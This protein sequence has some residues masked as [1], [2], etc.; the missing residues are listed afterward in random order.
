MISMTDILGFDFRPE[1]YYT[2]DH[3]WAKLEADGTVKVGFDDVIAK[4][5]HEIFYLKLNSKGSIAKQKQKL[6]VLESRK[7]TGPIPSPISGEILAVN[8]DVV[9]LGAHAF[10]VDPYDKGW[11]FIMKP[12]NLEVELKALMHGDVAVEWFT[13]AAEPLLDELALFKQKH[14]SELE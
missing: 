9:K 7:Y 1:L 2:L 12:S 4:G 8:E 13:K 10:E 14:K 3:V 5:A 6:G 11:L